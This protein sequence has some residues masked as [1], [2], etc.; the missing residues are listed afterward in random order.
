MAGKIFINYRRDDSISTAGRL[1]DRLAQTFGRKNLFMDVDHVPAG[2]DF[3]DYLPSQV[4]ACDVFLAVIGPNWLDAKDDDGRRRFDN[5]HDFVTIEIAAALARNIR[6]IPVLVDGA[7]TPKAD[8]LPDSIKPLVRCNA[9]EVRNT[10]FGRDAEALANKVREAL[11]SARPVTGWSPT[12][13][14]SKAAGRW[15][16]V[17]GSAMALLLVGWIGLYQSGVPVWV[18]WTPRAEQPDAPSADKAKAAAEAEALRKASEAEQ[19]RLVAAKAEEERKAAEASEE[20]ER[21]RI[22]AAK[23][24]AADAEARRRAEEQ[25]RAADAKAE[26]ERKAAA[27]AEA[28]RRAAEKQS[29]AAPNAEEAR[30]KAEER[31]VAAAKAEEE[32]KA[33]AAAADA[34]ARRKAEEAE[35]QRAKPELREKLLPE[36][37]WPPPRASA[38]YVLPG[39]LLQNHVSV[40]E[41]TGA[42]ISA[43]ERNGYV[44]RSFFQTEANGVAL[45]TR[46]ERIKDDGSA[47]D[48]PER[49]PS[50]TSNAY[51][52]GPSALFRFLSGLFVVDPGR[53]RIIVF[54]LQT[55]P[56]SQSLQQITAPEAQAW[57]FS[58]ANV[59]PPEVA[60]RPFSGA[61]C[62]ALIYEFSS[63]GSQV[64]VIESR[65]TGKDHLTKAG[66]LSFLEKPN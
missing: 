10:H 40:G 46:L 18:P 45:V 52:T 60:R 5:P 24:A 6:V 7:P 48:A 15:P 26:E 65:L 38:S 44:E 20:A 39:N 49:W 19:Q 54:I 59:L 36:F 47:F 61:Y 30:R 13:E 14:G 28:R 57:L 50:F 64:R 41:V 55:L 31:R 1:H 63:D 53:Y 33:K 11:K 66:V 3:V 32:R 25:Q 56:F 29:A 17:A 51:D 16:I 4:A 2:V 22:A 9:V 42:I 34:E 58:G 27:D 8:K 12:G 21:Q 43:L 35:Q 62:T 23:A 37:P